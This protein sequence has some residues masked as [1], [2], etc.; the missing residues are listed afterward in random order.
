MRRDF[1]DSDFFFADSSWKTQASAAGRQKGD[2]FESL[3]SLRDGVI[4]MRVKGVFC[5]FPSNAQTL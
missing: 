3:R 4:T 1:G 2:A 5:F